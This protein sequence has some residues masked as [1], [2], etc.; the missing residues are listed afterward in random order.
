MAVDDPTTVAPQD[1]QPVCL[2]IP[3]LHIQFQPSKV[4]DTSNALPVPSGT[5]IRPAFDPDTQAD[6]PP[7]APAGGEDT[8]QASACHP[9]TLAMIAQWM[10]MH[11]RVSQGLTIA[12]REGLPGAGEQA[13]HYWAKWLWDASGDPKQRKY[14]SKSVHPP[15]MPR[16]AGTDSKGRPAWNIEHDVLANDWLQALKRGGVAPEKIKNNWKTP[17]PDGNARLAQF[18]SLIL[19]HGPIA[20]NMINPGHFV[21][22]YGVRPPYVYIHDPGQVIIAAFIGKVVRPSWTTLMNAGFL[23]P[24]PGNSQAYVFQCFQGTAGCHIAIDATYPFPVAVDKDGKVTKTRRFIDAVFLTE[25]YSF[26]DCRGFTEFLNAPAPDGSTPSQ[27]GPIVPTPSPDTPSP[28][29]PPASPSGS[30]TSPGWGDVLA[31]VAASSNPFLSFLYW[32]YE[33]EKN[34]KPSSSPA[35]PSSPSSPG[36]QPAPG[37]GPK[38]VVV[39]VR[40]EQN[41]EVDGVTVEVVAVDTIAQGQTAGGSG[42]TSKPIVPGQYRLRARKKGYGPTGMGPT[43]EGPAEVTVDLVA[44]DG[45][46]VICMENLSLARLFGYV[47]EEPGNR[48]IPAASVEAVGV[49]KD[50][51]DYEGK[52]V[53][54]RFKPG[55][56]DVYTGVPAGGYGPMPGAGQAPWEGLTTQRHTLSGGDRGI[57]F[58]MNRVGRA[59]PPPPDGKSIDHAVFQIVMS[60]KEVLHETALTQPQTKVITHNHASHEFSGKWTLFDP[61]GEVVDTNA[62]YLGIG[63][64]SLDTSIMTARAR[65]P[66]S[67]AFGEWLLRLEIG[68]K[69]DDAPFVYVAPLPSW[70]G[71]PAAPQSGATDPLITS[72]KIAVAGVDFPDWFNQEL[73]KKPRGGLF[74]AA[75]NGP[76]FHAVWDALKVFTDK[77]AVTLN[78]FV[79]HLMIMYNETGGGLA[80][81]AEFPQGGKGDAYFFEP[82]VLRGTDHK[83]SY[84]GT[85]GNLLAGN[86]LRTAKVIVTDEDVAAWNSRETYPA[87]QPDDVK[88]AARECDFHKYRGHGL[89]QL[90]FRSNYAAHADG[91]LREV[92]GKTSAQ[93]TSQELDD[94]FKDPRVYLRVF[95]NFNQGAAK[96]LGDVIAGNFARYGNLVAGGNKYGPQIFEPRCKTLRD[97]MH[98]ATYTVG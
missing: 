6:S 9:A 59:H 83:A 26:P 60:F 62:E 66:S 88:L 91:P 3:Q 92:F 50:T 86:Q 4:I 58:R 38:P 80:S 41:K 56:Y 43:S 74:P 46:V 61:M 1:P 63:D 32:A 84:N 69:Y 55:T 11:P 25:N 52:V 40:D 27:P 87:D 53:S 37:T 90:T 94:A 13:A 95:R 97:L 49:Y 2:P 17:A 22:I 24:G 39:H 72:S 19:Q 77:D 70:L 42:F 21:L 81:V 45:K 12:N 89:N 15:F 44:G 47:V 7:G 64:Y 33:T 96:A 51:T 23:V 82:G 10:T 20:A 57:L 78:E 16:V 54:Y 65:E 93:M 35:G 28:S 14:I 18:A 30:N 36:A 8:W 31:G 85:M 79:A 34:S 5:V 75:L 98:S 48:A 73:F 71:E 67:V 29:G 76:N 68:D